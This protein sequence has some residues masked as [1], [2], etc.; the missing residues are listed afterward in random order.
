M[1]IVTVIRMACAPI[2]RSSAGIDAHLNVVERVSLSTEP[3]GNEGHPD[4]G[5]GVIRGVIPGVGR[6]MITAMHRLDER[7]RATNGEA[8]LQ[9]E[10]PSSPP[11]L[12]AGAARAL[13]RVLLKDSRARAARTVHPETE[14]EVLAS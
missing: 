11:A 5:T 6:R 9:I 3:P 1:S 10:V 13:I 14:V 12:T 2:S 4:H 7:R 8:D